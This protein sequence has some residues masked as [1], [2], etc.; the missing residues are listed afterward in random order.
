MKTIERTLTDHKIVSRE[1]WVAARKTLL[2]KEKEVMQ[3]HDQL[4]AERRALP[5]VKIEKEYVFTSG[6]GDACRP[7]RRAQPAFHQ[8][9]HD[10]TG[11]GC[12]MRGL[13]AGSR[14]Y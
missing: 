8:A 5:W 6:E 2:A 11:P 12:A 3:L 13:L 10:G 14:P 4:G 1:E 9:L 7:V